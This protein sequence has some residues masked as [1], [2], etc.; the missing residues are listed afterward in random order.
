MS[1]LADGSANEVSPVLFL[2]AVAVTA[3]FGGLWPGLLAT[4][5]GFLA[6]DYF[7]ESPAYSLAVSDPRTLLESLA[8][9]L[10]AVLLG[11]LNAQLRRARIRA[12]TSLAE[13]RAA[14]RARD[15][16]LAAVS[17]DMRT[18][19]TA[20]RA[21]VAALEEADDS[22][23]VESRR[24][25]LRNV[26]G[27]TQ[28]LERFIAD[29]LALGRIEA[30]I[31]PNLTLNAPGE[32]V[33]A[34]LDRRMP[35]LAGREISFDAPDTLPLVC[36]DPALLEQALGNLLD[37]VAAHTPPGTQVSVSGRIDQTGQLRL[38]VADSGPGIPPA[39]RE[40][41]FRKFERLRDATS[42]AGLGLAIARAAIEAQGGQLWVE[43]GPLGGACFVVRLPGSQHH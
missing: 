18:P 40:R 15:E 28:R 17:H 34:I 13:A 12:E 23:P 14:V 26:A 24:R 43:S 39:D 29:A 27:E 35:V 36:F 30:G 19:L 11:T 2:G 9:V 4:A 16:A 38:E 5:L 31:Q 37:N 32:V 8:Y 3:W 25:L 7:F 41:I 33:S 6:L 1:L 21:T 42:G 22:L 10:I 20:I